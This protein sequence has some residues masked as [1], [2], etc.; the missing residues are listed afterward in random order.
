MTKHILITGSSGYVG[1]HLADNL[2]QLGNKVSRL[3]VKNTL[4]KELDFRQYDAIIHTAALVHNNDTNAQLADYF[5]VNMHLTFNLAMKAKKSGVKHFVFMSTMAVF[6]E[7]GKIGEMVEL[8]NPANLKPMTNYGISKAKAEAKIRELADDNFKVAIIRPPMIY[9]AGSPGN[10]TK[11]IKVAKRLPIIPNLSNARSALY[12]K[13]LEQFVNEII[14]HEMT[15]IYH[16]KDKFEFNTTKIV[17]EIRKNEH[18]NTF[19]LPIP[20]AMYPILNKV[21]VI[22]KIYGNLVYAKSLYAYESKVAIDNQE[23][24]TIIKDIMNK[25]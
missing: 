2:E 21:R 9:G 6:G 17:T 14:K 22:S 15:G 18:K 7:N 4:W 1:S 20:K 13:H 24:E 25:Y 12:I 19:L 5:R 8:T 10:F 23:F 11:L 16:P 3:N